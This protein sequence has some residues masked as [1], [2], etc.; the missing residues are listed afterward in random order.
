MNVKFSLKIKKC[1]FHQN[2]HLKQHVDEENVHLLME[3][4]THLDTSVEIV[5]R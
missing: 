1:I 3:L 5:R 2:Q 4:F